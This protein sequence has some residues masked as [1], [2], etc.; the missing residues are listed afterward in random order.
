[1]LIVP[2]STATRVTSR[3]GFRAEGWAGLDTETIRTGLQG[4]GAVP[5]AL[6]FLNEAD[7]VSQRSARHSLRS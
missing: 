5:D 2:V 6:Q 1:M 4:G 3:K 7:G